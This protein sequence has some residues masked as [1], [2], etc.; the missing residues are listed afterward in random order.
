MYNIIYHDTTC[1]VPGIL[2]FVKLVWFLV[3]AL[4]EAIS[5]GK[6]SDDSLSLHLLKESL[7]NSRQ[8]EAYLR[9]I[10]VSR[11]YFISQK[12]NSLFHLV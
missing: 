11:I 2:F 3:S 6:I 9:I 8:H 10:L 1:F 7:I 5:D 4:V 12:K